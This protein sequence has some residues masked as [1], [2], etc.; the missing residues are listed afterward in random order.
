MSTFGDPLKLARYTAV[1]N[2]EAADGPETDRVKAVELG[3][4]VKTAT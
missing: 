2:G 1:R 3:P 4:R